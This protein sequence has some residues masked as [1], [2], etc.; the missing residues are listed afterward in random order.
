MQDKYFIFFTRPVYV[1]D[2]TVLEVL[3]YV[4]FS[5]FGCFCCPFAGNLAALFAEISRNIRI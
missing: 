3:R 5:L 4:I 1:A 2:I